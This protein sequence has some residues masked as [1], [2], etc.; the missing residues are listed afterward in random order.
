MELDIIK[1]IEELY[2]LLKSPI[3]Q[4]FKQTAINS[5]KRDIKID[6]SKMIGEYYYESLKENKEKG[7]VYTPYPI[8]KYIVEN[9]I[10]EENII[11]NPYIKITDPACGAGNLIIPCF[12]HLY[13][14]YIENLKEVNKK[15][16]LKLNENN[17]SEHIIK[18]NLF[19]FDIDKLALKIL[20][21]DLFYYS[22]FFDEKNFLNTDFLFWDADNKF[23]III[24]NPPYVGP[25]SINKEYS[26]KLKEAYKNIFKDKSDISY[27]FFEKSLNVCKSNGKIGFITSRYFLESSSGSELR[28]TLT[29]STHI[30]RIVDF[31]GV[32]PFKGIGIDPVIIFMN[33]KKS[34]DM[35][36]K[37]VEIIKPISDKGR[38]DDKFYKSLFLNEGLEYSKFLISQKGLEKDRWILK[39]DS[40]KRII[41][42]I[43]EKCE[44]KLSDICTSHQGIITGCDKAFVV[45]E[46]TVKVEKLEN[47]ILK[48]WIK[49][50]FIKQNEVNRKKS[51]LIYSDSIEDEKKY[52]NCINHIA[53]YKQ[54]LSGRRECVKGVR[55]WYQLQWGRNKEIFEK[56]KIIFPFKAASNKFSLDS[57]SYFS[58]DVYALI[59][60]EDM[61][62]NY[63]YLL[64]ILNSKLYEFYFKSFAKKL[65]E[66]LYEYY[67]NN[68][69]KL[70]IPNIN[71]IE[72]YDNESLYKYF[73]LTSE[74]INLIEKAI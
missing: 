31:Y 45:D 3:D 13:N 2:E 27:C 51:Y 47:D 71:E 49:G 24:G 35:E 55:K 36:Y 73:K 66:D 43:E 17:L 20:K 74:E 40:V 28:K 41:E 62:F 63:K 54:K 6:D 72:K 33:K 68:L 37:D 12:L 11:N 64:Y 52:L 5:F 48:P 44:V 29:E 21:I 16:K 69:M 4:V 8:S 14:I 9:T 34:L 30:E 57:G 26:L 15:N 60:K 38:K 10:I 65:G 59:L 58:A 1:K 23:D 70:L 42:K 53:F 32:R 39:S 22:N 7:I 19:G 50:S 67:P 61:E 46:I 56:E 18:N 25:K